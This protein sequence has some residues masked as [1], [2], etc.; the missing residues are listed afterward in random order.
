MDLGHWRL[1]LNL[2]NI[3]EDSI[4]FVY[5]IKRV[6]PTTKYYIGKKV[7]VNKKKRK[8][9]KGRK[10]AR[11]YLDESDWKTYCGS[12]NK[13]KEDISKLGKENFTFE[14]LAFYPSKL[15]LGYNETKEIL[16]RDAIFR[17]DYYNEIVNCRLRNKK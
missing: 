15:L 2:K 8:P 14:I 12:S 17:D 9:L 5:I 4:G 3:P 10:N 16:I 11:R 13:L 6:N 1:P 7:L